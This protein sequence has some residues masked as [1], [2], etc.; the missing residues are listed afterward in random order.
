MNA[1]RTLL[2]PLALALIAG[3]LAVVAPAAVSAQMSSPA[4][5]SA[6]PASGAA[7]PDD[8]VAQ[9]VAAVA[10]RDVEG[11]MGIC[12]ADQI[13][14]GYRFDLAA[15]RLRSFAFVTM[16]AP[17]SDPFYAEVN[18]GIQ[19]GLIART[20]ML[21]S[22]SLLSSETVDGRVIAPVD[23]ER[24]RRFLADVDSDRLAGLTLLDSRFPKASMERDPRLLAN[25]ETQATIYG[26]DEVTERGALVSFEAKEYVL[27]FTLI[28]YGSSWS[29]AMQSSPLLGTPPFGAAE[30]TT[31]EEFESL[32]DS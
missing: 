16:L 4:T 19:R 12:A 1:R 28:R 20:V 22:Y 10:A 9:Y 6:P 18:R 2:T 8:A 15:E 26:A 25:Y 31:R 17:G 11:L 27:G 23:E 3:S 5:G 14:S 24:I 32:T 30:P 29:V 13:A 21:L 7:T